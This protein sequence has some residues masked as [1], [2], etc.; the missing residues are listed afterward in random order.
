MKSIPQRLLIHSA[1]LRKRVNVDR[2]GDGELDGGILLKKIRIEPSSQIIR[3]KNNAEIQLAATLFW[4]CRN[5]RPA[6][7]VI[8]IDDIVDFCGEKYQV[9]GIERLYDERRLHHYEIGM[10]K[11][12]KN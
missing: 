9:K 12:A 7:M 2:W 3:D 5:S 11:Y 10:I 8:S 6:G 1:T 4:D